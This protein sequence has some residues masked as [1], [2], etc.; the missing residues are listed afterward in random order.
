M[1]DKLS[2]SVCGLILGLRAAGTVWQ[3]VALRCRIGW[4][5]AIIA[6]VSCY[7]LF[8]SKESSMKSTVKCPKPEIAQG[9]LPKVQQQLNIHTAIH[10]P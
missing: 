5:L 1:P 3:L 6:V 2:M 8:S 10:K 4:G 7:V 9:V